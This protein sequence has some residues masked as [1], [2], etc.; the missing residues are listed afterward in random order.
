ME[1]FEKLAEYRYEQLVFCHDKATGLRAI[2]ALHSNS[3]GILHWF[4]DVS[5][6]CLR[7][8]LLRK[9]LVERNLVES[10]EC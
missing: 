9:W 4:G 3:T 5:T 6:G 7:Q 8:P 10:K 2:I 1:V